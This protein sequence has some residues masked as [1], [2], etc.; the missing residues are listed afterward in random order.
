MSSERC[1]RVVVID[2]L[3]YNREAENSRMRNRS[4][5]LLDKD[6]H[7]EDNDILLKCKC[8]TLLRSVATR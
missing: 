5:Y 4:L 2:G 1:C 6:E 7:P 3:V 8:E